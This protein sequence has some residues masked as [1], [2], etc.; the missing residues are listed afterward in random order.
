ML[1]GRILHPG[2]ADV[3]Q[4]TAH[5]GEKFLLDLRAG[6]LGSLLDSV[7]TILDSSGKRLATC[8]DMA[9]GQTDS[10][11][12]WNVPADGMYRIRVE[13]R[14]PSRGGPQYAYRLDVERAAAVARLPAAAGGR[15][16]QCRT[17]PG[18]PFDRDGR[19]QRAD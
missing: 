9:P 6:R 12:T 19:T 7:L 18:G 5:K 3:W 2:E 1:N 11:L 14:L 10:R 16:R 13:D 17:G 8:D 4:V 15:L